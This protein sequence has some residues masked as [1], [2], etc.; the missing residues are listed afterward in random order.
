MDK[1]F[2]KNF[3]ELIPSQNTKPFIFV[4]D[5]GTFKEF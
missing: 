1:W 3:C 5:N 4:C 2:M